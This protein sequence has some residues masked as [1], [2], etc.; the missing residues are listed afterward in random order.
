[1]LHILQDSTS[2][3]I[4]LRCQV[5]HQVV[6]CNYSTVCFPPHLYH[7]LLIWSQRDSAIRYRYVATNLTMHASLFFFT[8]ICIDHSFGD[9]VYT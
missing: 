3:E 2:R 4:D 8:F 1:M 6:C 5:L 9:Y 7:Y